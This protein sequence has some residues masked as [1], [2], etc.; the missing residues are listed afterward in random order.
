[1]THLNFTDRFFVTDVTA[2]LG[3]ILFACYIGTA[4]LT[5]PTTVPG[6]F[7][8]MEGDWSLLIPII[9]LLIASVM[10]LDLVVNLLM[11][12]RYNWK[13]IKPRRDYLYLAG[14]IFS[15]L[16]SWSIAKVV[17]VS[18]PGGILYVGFPLLF[19]HLAGSDIWAKVK[20]DRLK[21]LQGAST[22]ANP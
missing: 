15:L 5:L 4:G 16:P 1:M 21:A 6:K 7:V 12:P 20:N 19:I 3:G 18:G 2:R 11:S 22:H 10:L 8:M 9:N 17:G 14:C 13:W